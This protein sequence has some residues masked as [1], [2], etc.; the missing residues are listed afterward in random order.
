MQH[1]L[2]YL[3]FR[4]RGEWLHSIKL[5][6]IKRME[7]QVTK[8][9]KT[10]KTAKAKT[11]K[12]EAKIE[13]T[14]ANFMAKA[15]EG[16]EAFTERAKDAWEQVQDRVKNARANAGEALGVV[17]TSFEA[18]GAGV[19]DVNLKVLEFVQADANTYFETVKKV[20][21]AKSVKEAFEVQVA[22]LRGQFQ[23]NVKNVRTVREIAAEAAK[24]AFAP[25][26]EGFANLRTAA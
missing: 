20:A 23:T 11:A 6:L 3:P 15:R 26:R 16:V 4:G 9:A 8:T 21:T 7:I 2:P 14:S 25:V 18:A 12:V 1:E 13:E 24:E 22:Y 5:P 10:A 19:R 17:R